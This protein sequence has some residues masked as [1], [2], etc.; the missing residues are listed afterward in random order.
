MPVAA[1]ST[2]G[3]GALLVTRAQ[4]EAGAAAL[5]GGKLQ[6]AAVAQR[7][8]AFYLENDQRQAGGFERLF[9]RPEGFFVSCIDEGEL[10]GVKGKAGKGE[11][12]KP[13]VL[14][15][16]S[17]PEKGPVFHLAGKEQGKGRGG[18]A[19]EFM[20]GARVE[21]AFRQDAI[22]GGKAKRKRINGE[23]VMADAI[24]AGLWLIAF[25]LLDL[26]A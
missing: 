19:G 14:A 24:G 20:N 22:N 6:A 8:Q 26:A 15:V 16:V 12:V 3:G 25:Q 7:K 11:R 17:D 10:A 9:R 5:A 23:G 4:D 2:V 18:G 21:A 13:V 1:L